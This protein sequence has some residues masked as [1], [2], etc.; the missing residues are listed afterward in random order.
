M[1][2][3]YTA[4]P[5]LVQA[6]QWLPDDD[7]QRVSIARW[8]TECDYEYQPDGSLLLF[9]DDPD[10]EGLTVPIRGWI[11]RTEDG[12]IYAAED[13]EFQDLFDFQD[14]LFDPKQLSLF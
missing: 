7:D 14:V 11:V 2:G 10:T 6:A 3:V 4:K 1:I 9:E 13:G 8:L 12:G 5:V